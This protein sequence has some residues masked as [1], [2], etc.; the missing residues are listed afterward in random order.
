M[1]IDF[2]AVLS[3]QG[4]SECSMN[5]T[6]SKPFVVACI[7][8]YNEERS[9]GGVVVRALRHVDWVVV[10]DDGS[11]DLTGEIAGGLGAL[12]VRHERNMSYGA[13]LICLLVDTEAWGGC[14]G[15]AGCGMAERDINMGGYLLVGVGGCL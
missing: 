7:P 12:V 4:L 15:D 14:G 5:G 8:A 11:W 1:L 6:E 9:I 2:K 13:S 10:C 3:C